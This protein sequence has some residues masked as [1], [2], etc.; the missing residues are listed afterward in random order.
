MYGT[1]G[2]PD[3]IIC[4]NGRFV[5]LE[6]KTS[7]GKLTKIQESTLNRME[8]ISRSAAETSQ[9]VSASNNELLQ[10]ARAAAE[11]RMAAE[12]DVTNNAAS[13]S[14][15]RESIA[16]D[17]ARELERIAR[18][19][20][21]DINRLGDDLTRAIRNQHDDRRRAALQAIDDEV[22]AVRS[23]NWEK[24]QIFDAEFATRMMFLDEEERMRMG[25]LQA[26]IDAIN[27]RTRAEEAAR[28]EREFQDRLAE[29]QA[30][31]RA[32]TTA[33][34]AARIQQDVNRLVENRQRELTREQRNQRIDELRQQMAEEQR[35][36]NEA[37]ST[38]ETTK[39]EQLQAE[40][41]AQVEHYNELMSA[42]ALQ[43]QAL[44]TMLEGNQEDML[45]LLD[46]YNPG[47]RDAGRTF[48]EMLSTGIADGQK[49]VERQLQETLALLNNFQPVL[50]A[51]QIA[52]GIH[53]PNQVQSGGVV[54]SMATAHDTRFA[55]DM[56]S[57]L[58]TI[59][60]A[61]K[62]VAQAVEQVARDT[63]AQFNNPLKTEFQGVHHMLDSVV[64]AIHGLRS[65]LSEPRIV[66]T[67]NFHGVTAISTNI[68]LKQKA[69]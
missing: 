26:E 61:V 62:S 65:L 56:R 2:M 49:D 14:R 19:N 51:P 36:I 10:S 34:E 16:R 28:R 48:A 42:Q 54:G 38:L 11:G 53:L 68:I 57:I 24:M 4:L 7:T 17:E 44:Q 66:L 59:H 41:N 3:I 35:V 8:V 25:V 30:R 1:A 50:N 22:A 9:I 39:L 45:A 58:S 12:R 13:A 15:D 67:N 18:E 5:A 21:A 64:S 60:D 43:M 32:A 69:K 29:L 40:R 52:G 55:D 47:W 20:A 63:F 31:H 33:E 23:A 27:E 6:V 37:R 46:S